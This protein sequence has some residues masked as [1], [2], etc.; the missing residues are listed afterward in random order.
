MNFKLLKRLARSNRWQILFQ[1]AKELGTLKLFDNAG[2]LSNVQ[3]WMLYFL[4]QYEILYTDLAAKEENISEDVI[5]DPI[6]TEAY[7]L[8]KK[9]IR[10]KEKKSGN[11]DTDNTIKKNLSGIPSVIFKRRVK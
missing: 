11:E 2:D 9:T 7:L 3:I 8:W 10:D 5:N 4:Q 6:R 1:R